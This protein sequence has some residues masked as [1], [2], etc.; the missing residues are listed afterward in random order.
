MLVEL[1]VQHAQLANI[2]NHS[3]TIINVYVTIQLVLVDPQDLVLHAP[4]PRQIASM[5]HVHV[6]ITMVL[7]LM[8]ILDQDHAR[9]AQDQ[10][11]SVIVPLVAIYALIHKPRA[12]LMVLAQTAR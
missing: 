12:G 11:R 7:V 5:A 3:A 9:H 2:V 4:E 1:L 8:A 6:P 10:I